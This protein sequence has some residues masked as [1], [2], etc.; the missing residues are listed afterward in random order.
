MDGN[1]V[2]V[3]VFTLLF[4]ITTSVSVVLTGNRDLISGN[5]LNRF[6]SI[7]LD[8]RFIL[9]FVLA[10]LSRLLFIFINNA[11][12]S[13]ST[14]AK[15]STTVTVFITSL[16]YFAILALNI[17]FLHETMSLKQWGGAVLVIIGIVLL[18]A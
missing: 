16:S 6:F 12:L 17:I 8:W 1:I 5:L 7:V 2:K 18:T 14:L 3:I 13:I 9:A 11:L 4:C 10:I 15:N